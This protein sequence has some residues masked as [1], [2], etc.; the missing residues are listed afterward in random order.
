MQDNGYRGRGWKICV[1][2]SSLFL[3]SSVVRGQDAGRAAPSSSPASEAAP[4][5]RALADMV[6]RCRR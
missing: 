2:A 3:L 4:E 1:A 5:I 6:R